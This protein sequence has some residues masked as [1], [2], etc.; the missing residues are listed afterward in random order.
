MTSTTTHVE[1]IYDEASVL[2]CRVD[3]IDQFSVILAGE[4][5]AVALCAAL[6]APCLRV[7]NRAE[8]VAESARPGQSRFG[9]TRH[10]RP[11]SCRRDYSVRPVPRRCRAGQV[12]RVLRHTGG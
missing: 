8:L 10:K 5:H 11:C 3:D 2:Y 12:G 1:Y 7:K 9:S 4:V 6:P